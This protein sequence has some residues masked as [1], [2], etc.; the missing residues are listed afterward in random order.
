MSAQI[1]GDGS[2]SKTGAGTM[3]LSAANTYSGVT[4]VNNGT[5]NISG[6]YTPASI[7]SGAA[8]TVASGATM[9]IQS[10]GSYTLGSDNNWQTIDGTLNIETGGSYTENTQHG[11]QVGAN[12][13]SGA[14][15]I[16]GGT[17]TVQPTGSAA[18]KI[19]GDSSGNGVLTVSSGT[20]DVQTADFRIASGG[21]SGEVHLDG[22]T[23]IAEKV[24]ETSGTST[25]N[26][27]G[28]TLQ[29]SASEASFMTG[30]DTANVE[31]G[32]AIIDTDGNDITI[33][34]ALLD[35]GGGGGLT[36]NSTGTLTLSGPSTYTGGTTINAGTVSV[37]HDNALGTGSVTVDN[38][39]T[40][41]KL[42]LADGLTISNDITVESN[43]GG[44]VK[45]DTV[46]SGTATISGLVTVTD[47]MSRLGN[48]GAI[49]YDGGLTSASSQLFVGDANFNVSPLTLGAGELVQHVSDTFFGVTG[50]TWSKQVI[51]FGGSTTIGVN[52]ALPTSSILE[53]GWSTAGNSTGTIDLNGFDQTVAALQTRSAVLGLGG[54]QTVTGTS[55]TLTV[56]AS[57]SHAYEG[58]IMGGVGLTKT[59]S[60]TLTLNN[61]SGTDSDHSGATTVNGGVL[62]AGT[63]DAFSTNSP[64]T[65]G[66]SGTLRLDGNSVTIGS[67]A[68]SGTV[69][70]AGWNTLLSDDFSSGSI[71]ADAR[72]YESRLDAGWRSTTGWSV[73]PASEWTITGGRLENPAT[74]TDYYSAG[75]TPA[76]LWWTNPDTDSSATTLTISFDYA[77]D[78][79]DTL[80]AHFWAVQTGGAAGTQNFISNNQGWNDGKSGQN[81]NTT[82]GGYDTFNLLDGDTT[83]DTV[84]HITGHL[85]G[86]GTFTLTIDVSELGIAGVTTVGDIDTLF[87]GFGADETGGGTT[88]VDNLSVAAG[89]A[90]L[91]TGGDSSSTTFSGTIQ[92]GSGGS[93]LALTKTGTGTNTLSGTCTYTGDT[94][95]EAGT[96]EVAGGSLTTTSVVVN[97][98]ATFRV[99]GDAATI[100]VAEIT[101]AS[102]GTFE[103]ALDA[104]GVSTVVDTVG[105]GLANASIVVDGTAY[106]GGDTTI[107]LFD[108]Q[109]LATVSSS[110]TITGFEPTYVASV[111]QDQDNDWVKLTI[112]SK[113]SIFRFR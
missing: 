75:E 71:T 12:G 85:S 47:G 15:N 29:A 13:N 87:I 60:G 112:T 51:A 21:G 78:G 33:A 97:A 46:G 31:G 48:S 37:S 35:G 88:W 92:D 57:T 19:G 2:V 103:F 16:N 54:N 107:F 56:N 44:T 63:S 14:L 39:D 67:L 98:S 26:F 79:S 106:T 25:F 55:G 108:S 59:G 76:W 53:L 109:N 42:E 30:L 80:T 73:Y 18:F 94:I 41:A 101:S 4:T 89:D 40:S 7:P 66:G 64:V 9:N 8:L 81:Q 32:G 38:G 69:E 110:V 90:I 102:S 105:S 104:D 43:G 5:L 36:K 6:A 111:D 27:N 86:T 84:D 93:A 99:S 23:L 65:V 77:T 22:G 34:Q 62:Q 24:V 49:N 11:M 1:S 68:G 100:Q 17:M 52:D 28:G 95:V 3:T 58:R 45:L 50:H 20:L 61:L 113:S 96:L 74:R 83:P 91:T 72:I 10:G 70:S 82:S